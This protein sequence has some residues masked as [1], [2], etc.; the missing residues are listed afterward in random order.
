MKNSVVILALALASSCADE[1]DGQCESHCDCGSSEFCVYS[2]EATGRICRVGTNPCYSEPVDAGPPPDRGPPPSP[3]AG[4]PPLSLDFDPSNLASWAAARVS[5]EPP[6]LRL[7]SGP[8]RLNT[9]NG[10]AGGRPVEFAFYLQTGAPPPADRIAVWFFRSVTIEGGTLIVEGSRPAA[11]IAMDSLIIDSG[12]ILVTA[13][14]W[15][16]AENRDGAS[17]GSGPGGGGF[18]IDSTSAGAGAGGSYCGL[19]GLPSG[20]DESMRG[21]RY[22]G[23]LI[24]PLAGGSGG[25]TN[26]QATAGDGGDGGG[27]LQLI[28]GQRL[29]VRGGGSIDARGGSG[30]DALATMGAGGGSGGSILVEAPIVVIEGA[31]RAGGGDGGAVPGSGAAGSTDAQ[32][33]GFRIGPNPAHGGGGGG[34]GWIRINTATGSAEVA[35]DALISPALSHGCASLGLLNRATAPPAPPP[36]C[37]APWVPDGECAGCSSEH[38]CDELTACSENDLCTTCRTSDSPG[39]A[40]TE[41]P[42]V[43]AVDRCLLDLCPTRCQP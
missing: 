2:G 20:G 33:G 26:G 12:R 28:A 14:G 5:D 25:G 31:L 3:D 21:A 18:T 10:S 34:F 15:V 27:A 39:P 41:S 9:D 42:L 29:E 16:G 17:R 6:S 19:G 23:P 7:L 11:I 22:G 8:V 1:P 38:C 35:V 37:S 40:C 32:D 36:S 43:A 24:S 4:P 30:G 13:G